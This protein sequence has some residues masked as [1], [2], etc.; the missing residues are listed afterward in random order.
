MK[1]KALA[2]VSMAILLSMGTV[3]V[4]AQSAPHQSGTVKAT[5][6][7]GLT[8]TT[9]A[10]QD[11]AV[12]LPAT[13]K[14][15]VVPPGA[16]A[17]AATAGT[18]ADVAVG[19]KAIVIGTA[20]DTGTTLT[21]TKVYLMK[22]AAI[23]QS[24]AADQAA[25]AQGTGG[26]VKSVDVSAG[27]V[28]LAS[29]MKTITL[30]TTPKTIVR[31]YSGS[32][33]SF[34]D[35]TTCTLADVKVGDQ[36]RVRGAK[37]ADGLA[38]MADEMVA[39]TF[40]NYSGLVSAVDATAGTVT[41]KDLTTKKTVTVAVTSSSDVK[42][43][44]PQMATMIAARMKN[45]GAGGAAPATADGAQRAR[46]AGADLSQMLSRFPAETL[47]GLKVGEAVMIVASSPAGDPSKATAVT[48][49]AG[50]DAI[51]TASPSGEM[52]LSPWSV[53]G[54]PDM[55]GGGPGGGK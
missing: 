22:S 5:A 31:H 26:I 53:G 40:H 51:L 35:A 33:V 12:T 24:H 6:D 17:S 14:V 4:Q 32:S 20:S 49:L 36:L 55:G 39:G 27:T 25:W 42:R 44:P 45:T 11:Y 37:S 34:A 15:L 21:A 18:P 28:V 10:G 2:Q 1:M 8:L 41:L 46:G 29:G 47:S 19:D 13:A 48:L 30:S 52:Q 43:I 50:V 54:A 16:A 7:G 9:A 3:A 38:I 23:A